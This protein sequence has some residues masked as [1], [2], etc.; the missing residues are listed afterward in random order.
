[1]RTFV[2]GECINE[3]KFELWDPDASTETEFELVVARSLS[4]VYPSHVCVMFSGGFRY[5]DRI[6]RPDMALIAR[7]YSHWFII[8]VELI[9]HS[10]QNHI[11]PQVRSFQYGEPQSDCVASLVKS[12]VLNAK[13]AETLMSFVPRTVAVIANKWN[14][15]WY[16]GLSALQIQL[17]AISVF[18]SKEGREAIEV[19]GRLESFMT[20]LGFGKYVAVDR[21]L[22][23]PKNLSIPD[24]EVQ[25]NDPAGSLGTWVIRRDSK[26]AWIEKANGTPDLPDNCYIQ[27]IRTIDGGFSFRRPTPRGRF[28]SE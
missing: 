20:H 12:N 11:L 2:V 15:D 10:F 14:P 26:F 16:L 19:T 13:Q 22:I 25:I 21:S 28:Y 6:Y 18:R 24:G 3:N 17:L 27:L 9:T 5:D 8:E 23:F 4:C 7:D 1:M